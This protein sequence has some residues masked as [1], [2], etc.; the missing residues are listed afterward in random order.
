MTIRERGKLHAISSCRNDAQI[1]GLELLAIS[2]GLSTFMYKIR[3]RKVVVHTDNLGAEWAARKATAK[4]W[5]HAQLV[6]AQ[7]YHAMLNHVQLWIT[8]VDTDKNVADLPSRGHYWFLREKGALEL[9]PRI[10]GPYLQPACWQ[11]LMDPEHD[12]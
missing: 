7:W 12:H 6:H 8:R 1:M 4:C 11:Y 2:L 3:N 10:D 5:D 9:E